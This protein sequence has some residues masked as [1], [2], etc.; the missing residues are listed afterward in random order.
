MV[1]PTLSNIHIEVQTVFV[2]KYSVP[3]S[4]EY[5]FSYTIT[6]KNNGP[7][8]VQLLFRKWEIFDFGVFEKRLVE[9]EG[10]VGEKPVIPVEGNY[11]YSSF[12]NLNSELGKMEGCY[13]MIDLSTNVQF[14]VPIP[15]FSLIM[16]VL[17]N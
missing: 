2:P 5:L 17:N 6:I 8:P 11:T 10:V 9:G 14:E 4:G 16:P 3:H 12:C 13:T 1:N 15:P 7:N